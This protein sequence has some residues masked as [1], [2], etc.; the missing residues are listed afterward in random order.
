MENNQ[1]EQ[2]GNVKMNYQFYK[3]TDQYSDGDI[4]DDI[5]R[6]VQEEKDVLKIL[7][8]DH[9]WPVLYHLS[10][11]RQNIL[12][13][14]PFKEHA[15]VLE[16]GAGCGAI[17]G[18]LCRHCERVVS[19]DLSKRRSLINANRN[20]EYGNLEIVVGN[21]NDVVLQEKFDY[22]TLIGVLEYAAY[23]T[24][25]ENPF[26]AFLKKIKEYLKEDGHLIIAIENKYG[27]KYWAG[28]REDHVGTFFEGIEGYVTTESPV[29]TFGKNKLTQI[30][31]EAGYQQLDYYYP[32]PDY[33]FPTQIFSDEHLPSADD[34][35]V[36][37]ETYDNS[38]Y[39]LFNEKAAYEGLLEEGMYDY[40]ANSF[41]VDICR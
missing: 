5:L 19:V 1:L 25:A 36:S 38:R 8:A 22:I 39:R 31:R 37:C 4:E 27:L 12:E 28:A 6:M 35:D 17:T 16:I 15:H 9:R 40:F 26:V 30:I 29:R 23:Y 21:F 41:L 33:K 10:P 14:Y 13:W 11:V 24:Q 2:I 20:R 3:G 7:K 18:A 32:F 34:L